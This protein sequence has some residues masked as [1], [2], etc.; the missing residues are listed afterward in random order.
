MQEEIVAQLVKSPPSWPPFSEFEALVLPFF[1]YFS[2]FDTPKKWGW[3]RHCIGMSHPGFFTKKIGMSSMIA[4]AVPRFCTV[5]VVSKGKLAS[6][7]P[8][9]SESSGTI[10]FE[11]MERDSST[12]GSPDSPSPR[13]PSSNNHEIANMDCEQ[14]FLRTILLFLIKLLTCLRVTSLSI[15]WPITIR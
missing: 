11:R 5:Y 10:R 7:R 1:T 4:T 14:W 3:V 12:S 2:I 6:V 9:D 15:P 13:V 8:S